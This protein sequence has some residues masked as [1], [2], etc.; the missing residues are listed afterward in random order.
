ME[1]ADIWCA[2]VLDWENMLK[3]EGFKVLDMIQTI[4]RQDGINLDTL[5]CPIRIDNTIFKSE[6]AAPTIGENTSKII[7]EFNL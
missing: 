1:P 7:S 3:H 4:K 5:R 2:E 6:K